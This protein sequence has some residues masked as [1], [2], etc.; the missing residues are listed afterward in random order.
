MNELMGSWTKQ[1]GYP[2]VF[3][4]LEG[5]KLE[6][7]QSQYL[8]SGKLG[9]GHWVIPVTLSYGSY[10]A[11]KNALLLEKLGSVSLPRDSR[12]PRRCWFPTKLDKDKCWIDCILSMLGL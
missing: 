1:K 11:C 5:D 12:F 10:S 7:E 6:L 4:K 8:S 2:V 3:D 9:H